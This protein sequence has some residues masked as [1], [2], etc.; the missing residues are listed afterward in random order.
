MRAA[1]N[2]YLFTIARRVSWSNRGRRVA[3]GLS[4]TRPWMCQL[5][6]VDK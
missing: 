5:L 1:V 2:R 4:G 3:R 6:V